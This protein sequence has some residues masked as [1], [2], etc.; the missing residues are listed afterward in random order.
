MSLRPFLSAF[1]FSAAAGALLS[2]A[3]LAFLE[4]RPWAVLEVPE[5]VPGRELEK[6]LRVAGI[7]CVSAFSVPVL[8]NDFDGVR[9]IPLD[10]YDDYVE[11]G[12]PRNDGYAERLRSF[13]MADGKCRFFL[14][15]GFGLR[16]KLVKLLPDLAG[17]WVL[18]ESSGNFPAIACAA[19]IAAALAFAVWEAV[20]GRQAAGGRRA[21]GSRQ[22]SAG[23]QGSAGGALSARRFFGRGEPGFL[24]GACCAVPVLFPLSLAG[25]PGIAASGLFVIL[26]HAAKPV[27]R[28]YFRRCRKGYRKSF[29]STMGNEIRDLAGLYPFHCAVSL[30][31]FPAY[32]LCC[33][34][35]GISPVIAFPAPFFFCVS[36]FLSFGAEASVDRNAFFP[37]PIGGKIRPGALIPPALPVF[38][39]ACAVAA[40]AAAQPAS[41]PFPH[42]GSYGPLPGPEEYAAHAEF[43]ASFLRRSLYGERNYGSYPAGEDGLISGFVPAG[44]DPLPPFPPYPPEL[45]EL[46][47]Q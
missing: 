28:E 12:D 19:F 44:P 21:A 30:G 41:T 33:L 32:I 38:L 13:F 27:L 1:F 9:E 6:T 34:A 43:Q 3:A 5:T 40:F 11:P 15:P 37:L 25:A 8:F 29:R 35:G 36:L 22:A 26:F 16:R 14:E 42:S 46:S 7:A 10:S 31:V 18:D 24:F 23:R 4:R 45:E 20:S 39:V 2:A 17:A 47:G